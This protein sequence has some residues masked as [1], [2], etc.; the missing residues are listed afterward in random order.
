MVVTIVDVVSADENEKKEDIIWNNLKIA[1]ETHNLK[2]FCLASMGWLILHQDKNYYDL[3]NELRERNFAT[4]LIAKEFEEE[5][6]YCLGLPL[7]HSMR[8]MNN[9]KYECLFSCRPP[10]YAMQELLEHS[11][12]Y[13]ENLEKL[14]ISG[15]IFSRK[16]TPTKP[17]HPQEDAIQY[18]T[19]NE[20]DEGEAI[21]LGLKKLVKR[22]YTD[23]Q[24]FLKVKEDIT[25]HFG[26]EPQLRIL[27]FTRSKNYPLLAFVVG[28]QVIKSNIFSL[29][30]HGEYSVY[31]GR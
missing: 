11:D 28:G 17:P 7:F 24:Y 30:E 23:S 3:E 4:Y 2:F 14:K 8:E 10:P 29:N 20:I 13:E 25:N 16:E 12:S 18:F 21:Q 22:E 31:T 1:D 9:F 6:D 26:K 27:G 19:E 15:S 5:S